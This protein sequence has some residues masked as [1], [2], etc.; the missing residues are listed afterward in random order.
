MEPGQVE[1]DRSGS[2]TVVRIRQPAGEFT[3]DQLRMYAGYLATVAA[4][5]D[6]PPP[7]PDVEALVA[8]FKGTEARYLGYDEALPVLARAALAA[9]YKREPQDAATEK[10]R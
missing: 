8:A 10:M 4:E 1:I 3:V 7:E 6:A 2:R 5:A 9:G